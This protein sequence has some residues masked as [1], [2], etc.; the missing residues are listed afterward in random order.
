MHTIPSPQDTQPPLLVGA[1]SPRRRDCRVVASGAGAGRRLRKPQA[2]WSVGSRHPSKK[3]HNLLTCFLG[4]TQLLDECDRI[5]S[6]RFVDSALETQLSAIVVPKVLDDIWVVEQREK[7]GADKVVVVPNQNAWAVMGKEV[8]PVRAKASDA[9]LEE[10]KLR[11]DQI[12]VAELRSGSAISKGVQLTIQSKLSMIF[13]RVCDSITKKYDSDATLKLIPQMCATAVALAEDGEAS[14]LHL[15]ADDSICDQHDLRMESHKDFI[16]VLQTGLPM[17]LK[18]DIDP[19]DE[20]LLAMMEFTM[21]PPDFAVGVSQ[22]Q[23]YQVSVVNRLRDMI[24]TLQI[25]TFGEL[26]KVTVFFLEKPSLKGESACCLSDNAVGILQNMCNWLATHPTA[27]GVAE[28]IL[29]TMLPLMVD[30]DIAEPKVNGIFIVAKK[31]K[32]DLL[33]QYVPVVA[34][35]VHDIRAL[36]QSRVRWPA[37]ANSVIMAYWPC[38]QALNK[39]LDEATQLQT[40][41]MEAGVMSLAKATQDSYELMRT[42]VFEDS[43]NDLMNA[44][45]DPNARKSSDA[46]YK[47]ALGTAAKRM[48]RQWKSFSAKLKDLDGLSRITQLTPAAASAIQSAVS[49]DVLPMKK[50][51]GCLSVSQALWRPL[52]KDETR[53]RLC[54]LCR[55]GLESKGLFSVIPAPLDMLRTMSTT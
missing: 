9:F 34:Q 36:V 51:V 23:K 11:L 18:N 46:L 48:Y 29:Y 22:F 5:R 19:P 33:T 47:M 1:W 6:T 52:K 35:E 21:A 40:G 8:R 25:D 17:I 49:L 39:F 27:T 4:G 43:M 37:G 16:T 41:I 7:E 44:A 12:A 45:E 13:E 15:C 31:E 38:V 50:V 32:V 28:S 20:H 2:V 14:G 53:M 54:A 24:H 3:F 26:T 42:I 55:A 10:H 30:K